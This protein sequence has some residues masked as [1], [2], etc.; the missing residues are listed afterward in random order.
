MNLEELLMR[1]APTVD[2]AI[3]RMFDFVAWIRESLWLTAIWN[4][5][6]TS[7]GELFARLG[8]SVI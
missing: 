8:W 1:I 3:G 2:A 7:L 5:I 6:F 4:W